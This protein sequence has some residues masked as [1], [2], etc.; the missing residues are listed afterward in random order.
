MTQPQHSPDHT[1]AHLHTVESRVATAPGGEASPQR[2]PPYQPPP[3][4]QWSPKA[5]RP[6]LPTG[7][8][9]LVLSLSGVGLAAF[10]LMHMGLLVT[11]LFGAATMNTLAGFLE[12]YYLLQVGA[13]GLIALIVIHIVISLRKLPTTLRQQRA[14]FAGMRSLRHFDT[15]TWAFQVVTAFAILILVAIHLW[16][17]LTSLPIEAEASGQRVFQTYL[18]FYAL[19]IVFVEGHIS[20]GLYRAAVKW[21][22]LSRRLSHLILLL[23]TG[24]FL[25]LGFTILASFYA[26]GGTVA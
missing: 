13:A 5:V 8:A 4:P 10:M 25:I 9:D 15:W 6:P 26:L 14:V 21:G 7:L 11:V 3:M 20:I 2:V 22:L 18:W 24:V 1:A 17:I 19:F 16:V 23:W 12:R